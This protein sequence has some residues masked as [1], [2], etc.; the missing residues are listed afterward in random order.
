MAA[1]FGNLAGR[2]DLHWDAAITGCTAARRL[3]TPVPGALPTGPSSLVTS[4]P[5]LSAGQLR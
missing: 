4:C 3:V 2:A 1:T 5:G